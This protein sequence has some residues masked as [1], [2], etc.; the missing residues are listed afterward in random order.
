MLPSPAVLLVATVLG[1]PWDSVTTYNWSYNLTYNP[2][3]WA[4]GVIPIISRVIS[5][6]INPKLCTPQSELGSYYDAVGAVSIS[7]PDTHPQIRDPRVLDL[8]TKPYLDP[9]SMQDNS[10]LDNLLGVV[11]DCYFTYSWGLGKA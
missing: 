9:Q 1:C 6:A 8:D 10:L 3:K 7:I 2:P 4:I 5:P 11:L